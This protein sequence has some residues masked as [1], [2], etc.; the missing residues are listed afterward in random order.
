MEFKIILSHGPVVWAIELAAFDL[1]IGKEVERFML[2]SSEDL[3]AV[4]DYVNRLQRM[5]G[6]DVRYEHVENQP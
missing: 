1:D 2:S 6:F 3:G 4:K 5:T